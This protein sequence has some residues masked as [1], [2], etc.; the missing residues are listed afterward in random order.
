MRLNQ[1]SFSFLLGVREMKGA[2]RG[3]KEEEEGGEGG[4]RGGGEEEQ[5]D[6]M[7]YRSVAS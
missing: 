6:R 3:T 5:I 2:Q 7:K 4:G 1:S